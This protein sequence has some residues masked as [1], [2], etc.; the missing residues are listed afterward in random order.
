MS[1]VRRP[2]SISPAGSLIPDPKPFRVSSLHTFPQLRANM[3]Q[4]KVRALFHGRDH[5]AP[6]TRVVEPSSARTAQNSDA[7]LRYLR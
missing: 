1:E 7:R 4:H 3:V 5:V 2:A 6:A